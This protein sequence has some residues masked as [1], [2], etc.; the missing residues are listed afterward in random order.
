MFSVYHC[1]I[2]FVYVQKNILM[3]NCSITV[4]SKPPDS[5]SLAA[6]TSTSIEASWQLPPADSWNGIIRG[7]KLFYKKKSSSGSLKTMLLINDGDALTRIVTGLNKYTEYEFHVLAFTSVG[8]GPNSTVKDER[9]K[10]DGK[11]STLMIS[12]F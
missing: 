9:T 8:D 4:P 10:E 3:F 12:K 7:F 5:F 11:K 2:F 1:H 6:K